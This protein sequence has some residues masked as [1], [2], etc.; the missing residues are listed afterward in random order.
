VKL[1]ATDLDGTLVAPGDVIHPRDRA[2]IVRA[3]DL[4]VLV[5]IAT[6]RL[7]NRTHPL[8]RSLGI[9]LPL[10]CA[11]GAVVA[12]GATEQILRRHSVPAD[13]IDAVLDRFDHAGLASFV[14]T[15]EVI[16]SCL[17]GEPYHPYMQG[18][19][20]TITAHANVRAASAWR[21]EPHAVVMLLGIGE[22]DAVQPLMQ[23]LAAHDARVDISSFETGRGTVLRVVCKG[24]SK[25]AALADLARELGVARHDVAVAGDFWNDLSMFEYAGRSFA[26]P[27]APEG[28]KAAATHALTHDVALH[29]SFADALDDWLDELS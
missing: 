10:V 17:R 19:S 5:T 18:W 24:I 14:M 15:D 16:H 25:G 7:T 29:G 26:M 27:H 22:R 20:E 1:F 8:A 13:L 12:C 11:D 4:G 9:V 23:E 3:R 6:G 2:A 21:S 28:V